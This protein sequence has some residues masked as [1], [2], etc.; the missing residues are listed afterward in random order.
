MNKPTK[1]VHI[2]FT[3]LSWALLIA[4]FIYVAAVWKEI[5]DEV[6]RH[7]AENGEFDLYGSKNIAFYHPFIADILMLALFEAC[8]FAAMKIKPSAKLDRIGN[9]I[10]YCAV[11]FMTDLFKLCSATFFLYWIHL[12]ARQIPM[13]TVYPQILVI[14][15]AVCFAAITVTAVVVKIKHGIKSK[16]EK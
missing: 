8:G 16:K 13:N 1:I 11:V 7:F 12:V 3:A 14:G 10:M 15:A 6:G 2:V 5:P 9:E 4:G